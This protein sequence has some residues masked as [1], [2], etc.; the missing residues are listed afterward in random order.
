MAGE[1]RGPIGLPSD[2]PKFP[3]ESNTLARGD[4]LFVWRTCKGVPFQH[5]AVD[6]GDGTVV[7]FTDGSGGVA[8]PSG[9]FSRFQVQRTSRDVISRQGRDA[10]HVVEHPNRLA[11]E[12]SVRRAL[13]L[14]GRRDYDLVFDNCEHLAM[15]CV[16]GQEQSR[17]VHA[18]C[19]RLGSAGVKVAVAGLVRS[20]SRLGAR[21]LLRGASPWLLAADAAQWV[22]EATGHHV[23]LRDS[24]HRRLAGKTVGL[25]ASVTVGTL[26]GPAGAALAGGLWVAGEAAGKLSRVGYDRVRDRKL[27]LR[28]RP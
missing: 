22:T 24:R 20:A 19:E 27:S 11:A 10:I 16:C 1:P 7:H 6:L 2:Q 17:Q 5:H 18:V 21:S 9:D 23:G 4:H 28:Q 8:G 26:G 3:Q 15:W 12:E 13:Q 14:V 25:A